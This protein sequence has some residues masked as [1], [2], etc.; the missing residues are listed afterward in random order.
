M[1]GRDGESLGL[2]L[3]DLHFTKN[4]PRRRK[5]DYVQDLMLKLADVGEIVRERQLP[6]VFL[7]GDLTHAA[8][9]SL[10][11]GD[12]MIDE[13]ESW[14]VPI[15]VCV[16]NH[17]VFGNSLKTLS[18]TW[19][20]HIFRRSTVV[21]Q[22]DAIYVGHICIRAVHYDD[23][24][25][26]FLQSREYSLDSASY[27]FEKESERQ[28]SKPKRVA[29]RMVEIIHAMIV[30]EGMHPSARQV[31]PDDVM[32]RADLILSGD[33]HPGWEE[34]HVRADGTVFVNPGA[35]CRRSVSES[36]CQRQV[37]AVILKADLSVE[38]V[39]LG[40]MRP[41]EKAF[42]LEGAQTQKVWDSELSDYMTELA[43]AKVDRVDVRARIEQ[44]AVERELPD[45]VRLMA[46]ERY[47]QHVEAS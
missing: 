6:R 23:G 24:I 1:R 10:D 16:G 15:Y 13:M 40:S 5:G 21:Q 45:D 32:T 39:A 34:P 38:Y 47:D 8:I 14:G 31:H 28:A 19:L 12:R 25:E 41:V 7:G 26:E 30:T 35:M 9:V 2:Y 46:L 27:F 22:L 18:S 44:L 17:D 29:K 36:D 43:E 33:Y 42:D 3:T 11:L 20:G 4:V 37:R